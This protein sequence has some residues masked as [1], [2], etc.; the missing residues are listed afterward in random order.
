MPPYDGSW[1]L[2]LVYLDDQFPGPTDFVRNTEPR[3]YNSVK[4]VR[5]ACV[6]GVYTSEIRVAPEQ[7]E[8]PG[9]AELGQTTVLTV[10]VINDGVITLNVTEIGVD[11]NGGGWLSVSENPTPAEP[12]QVP[13]GVSNTGTFD[14]IVDATS[15]SSAQWLDGQIWLKSDAV[16]EDSV[17]ISIHIL[18]AEAVEPVFWDT[19]RSRRRRTRRVYSGDG[20]AH[21]HVTMG[22]EG[23]TN[24]S[25]GHDPTCGDITISDISI[26]INYLFI[27]GPANTVLNNCL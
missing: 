11:G 4:W 2:N 6:E 20:Q 25:G 1:Y 24:Q 3:T 13:P 21:D 19:D 9:W 27:A 17:A 15:M 18:A 22:A 8:W 12:F 5:L 26:L 23:D 7:F 14:V 16:N 10:A